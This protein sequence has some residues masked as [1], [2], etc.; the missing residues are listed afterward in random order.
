MPSNIEFLEPVSKLRKKMFAVY[1]MEERQCV[2]EILKITSLNSVELQKIRSNAEMFI[3][4][5]RKDTKNTDNFKA[6]LT[7]YDLS[8][9][10]GV[11]LMCLAEAILRIPDKIT[12]E[13]LITDKISHAD[14]SQ[15]L[16]R[17]KSKFVNSTT[18]SLFLTGKLLNVRG[19]LPNLIKRCGEPIVRQAV[20]SAV[21]MLCEQFVLGQTIEQG[22]QKAASLEEQGYLFSYDMLGEEARTAN[23]AKQ[24][25]DRYMHAIAIL[26][27]NVNEKKSGRPSISIKLSALHPR[28]EWRKRARVLQELVPIVTKLVVEAKKY[29]LALTIDAEEAERLDLT[30]DVFTAVFNQDECNGWNG[31][32]IA[33]QAYQKRATLVIDYLIDLARHKKR[34]INLR[35]VKGAYW[36]TEIKIAQEKGLIDYPVFTRRVATDVSYTACATKIFAAT[37]A[38][39]PQFATHNAYTVATILELS[40]DNIDFEFQALYGMGQELYSVVLEKFAIPC[41]IYAPIGHYSYLFGYLIRRLLENGANNS[42]VNK[43]L[44]SE[45]SIA[46]LVQNPYDVLRH[47]ELPNSKIPLP[48]N[49]YTD[50]PNSRGVDYTNPLE[51][52]KVLE[53]VKSNS[54]GYKNKEIKIEQNIEKILNAAQ[55]AVAIWANTALLD[56]INCIQNMAGLL[57]KNRDELIALLVLEGHKTILDATSEVREAIDYC[58]YY[59][60][61]ANLDLTNKV[62]Q[63]PT[64][65]LN[66]Y[67]LCPRGVILCISPWNFP[68]AIFLGQIIAALITGNAVIAKPAHQTPK[69]ANFAVDLLHKAKIPQEVVQLVYGAGHEVGPKLVS[70]LR[71]CGVM[72][73]GSNITATS[74]NKLLATRDGPIIPFIAETGGQNVMIVDS[75]AL[76]EQVVV[77]VIASAFGSAGQ[78]CS[79]LRVLY[80]Q[81]DIAD[82][83]LKMLAGAMAELTIGNT[84]DLNTDI[85]PVIDSDA[86]KKLQEHKKYLQQEA[87][88]VYE[89]EVEKELLEKNFFPPSMYL[90]SNISQLKQEVFG[91]ILH[92]IRY[93]ADK[94][95]DILKEI[96]STRYGLTLGIHSRIDDTVDFIINHVHVGN[97]YV[98]RNMI[99]AVVGVQPF[100]GEG[101]SGTGPKAGG[102][103]Y[104]PRLTTERSI[105]TNTAAIGGNASLL[106]EN[107]S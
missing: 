84:Q 22:M 13:K 19:V 32:G 106:S 105:S 11:A 103:Y 90:I 95:A 27:Q 107:E 48:A 55:R 67:T 53:T 57:E 102:P 44:D 65:E 39:Y 72:L 93:D 59:A 76:P 96:N 91:P 21:K 35:L 104:L 7:E 24:Y 2:E 83:V 8:N 20:T 45:I 49:L 34:R 71:I 75:S 43:L 47:T 73:T 41:R 46:Q 62:L 12:I 29:N 101:L 17:N 58:W 89:V 56:R 38:I 82:N 3:A 66:Q 85:G 74:I 88:L 86:F 54:K 15:H 97:I 92:V 77:D 100:G 36:D 70:D 64:G 68:L 14:W 51:Y 69:I 5:I 50:R 18:W 10:E 30:L 63:G 31:L 60:K 4:E 61:Q 1:R 78:R 6:L 26:G 23:D 9:S 99:G 52:S 42:F 37:D 98:N 81:E 94:L 40:K 25:F 28:F 79:C 33:V 87:T 80:I 16:W